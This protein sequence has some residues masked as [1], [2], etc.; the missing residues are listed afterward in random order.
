MVASISSGLVLH[1]A[2]KKAEMIQTK[3]WISW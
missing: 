2:G 3:R 1:L